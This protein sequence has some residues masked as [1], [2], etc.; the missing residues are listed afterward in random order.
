M[1]RRD[2]AKRV[3]GVDNLLIDRN[4]GGKL[5]AAMNHSMAD[6]IE[7]AKFRTLAQPIDHSLHRIFMVANHCPVMF[8]RDAGRL[9]A[10]RRRTLERLDDAVYQFDSVRA[11]TCRF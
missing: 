4:R 2:L 5:T 10:E 11:R 8:F 9:E 6:G 1:Q 7:V 3:E